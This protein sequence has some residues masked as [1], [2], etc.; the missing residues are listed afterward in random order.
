[1]CMYVSCAHTRCD[2]AVRYAHIHNISSGGGVAKNTQTTLFYI[3]PPCPIPGNTFSTFQYSLRLLQ[4]GHLARTSWPSWTS[5]P[6]GRLWYSCRRSKLT[7]I[8]PATS[9]WPD[10]QYACL[11]LTCRGSEVTARPQGRKIPRRLFAPSCGGARIAA[12]K[13]DSEATLCTILRG[14]PARP[15]GRKIPGRLFAAS[16]GG[17]A[18]PQ[19]RK[20]PGTLLAASCGGVGNYLQHLGG[21]P[22][23][24]AGKSL[25]GIFIHCPPA[26]CR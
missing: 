15:Q 8:P 19:G 3:L 11:N 12:R 14:G 10:W 21:A 20:I 6:C 5:R 24:D 18:R 7:S 9:I 22:P 25:M 23:Q 2:H 13:E 1:M 4:L 26:G 16:C 17:P